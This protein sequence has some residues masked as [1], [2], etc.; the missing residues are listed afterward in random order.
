MK[1]LIPLCILVI[2]VFSTLTLVTDHV[3]TVFS[4]S[5]PLYDR[6][7]VV[8]DAGH[9]G[10]DGG[11]T[12]CTGE[13]ESHINLQIALCLDDLFHL[14]GIDTEMIRTTD[15]S[16]YTAGNTISARKLSDLKERVRIINSTENAILISIH[17]NTFSESEYRGAQVFYSTKGEGEDLAEKMQ[18]AFVTALN[19]G[20]NRKA[21]RA[22]NVYLMEHIE[23]TGVLVECGFISN[24]EEAVLLNTS[25]YQNNV[26]AVIAST[27]STFLYT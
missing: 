5:A 4:E 24:P 19:P 25:Q 22:D 20:S 14:I 17:Q 11:A 3:V 16:V 8:I 9:G 12:S 18:H 21:K 2:F 1:R 27:V 6:I 26:C 15:R 10:E 7:C 13:L 23:C